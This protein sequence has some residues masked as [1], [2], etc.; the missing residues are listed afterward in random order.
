MKTMCNQPKKWTRKDMQNFSE[1]IS[2][3]VQY[4]AVDLISDDFAHW[5]Q[6]GFTVAFCFSRHWL[7]WAGS[8]ASH[9]HRCVEQFLINQYGRQSGPANTR[10]WNKYISLEQNLEWIVM[11]DPRVLSLALLCISY[12]NDTF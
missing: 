4:V 1:I 6:C 8:E 10:Q 11:R 7:S 12:K 9:V 5:Q 2:R 3:D